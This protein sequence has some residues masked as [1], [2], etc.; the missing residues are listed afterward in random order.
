MYAIQYITELKIAVYATPSETLI[1]L[2]N[3]STYYFFRSSELEDFVG[4]WTKKPLPQG[5][6]PELR[7]RT[8]PYIWEKDASKISKGDHE[9]LKGMQEHQVP[10][11]QKLYDNIVQRCCPEKLAP[12][13]TTSEFRNTIPRPPVPDV[14]ISLGT[15][16]RLD[17]EDQAKDTAQRLPGVVSMAPSVVINDSSNPPSRKGGRLR[18]DGTGQKRGVKR[19]RRKRSEKMDTDIDGDNELSEA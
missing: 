10:D 3:S 17:D 16:L 15:P 9:I 4:R 5:P 13:F 1:I 19:D 18:R 8:T 11:L 2:A 7:L 14:G 6:D 12:T